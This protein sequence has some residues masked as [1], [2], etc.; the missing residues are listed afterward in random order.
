MK[1][2]HYSTEPFSQLKT[3]RYRKPPTKEEIDKATQIMNFR[4]EIGLYF[5]H[6]SFFFE[7]V[8]IKNMGY[9]FRN[10]KHDFWFKGNR[11]FEHVIDSSTINNFKFIIVETDEI[12]KFNNSNWPKNPTVEN[13]IKFFEER[14][15][16]R[17]KLNIIGSSNHELESFSSKYIGKLLYYYSKAYKTNEEEDMLKYAASVPHLMLY[18]E[19]GYINL[20]QPPIL[21]IIDNQKPSSNEL[22]NWKT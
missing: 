22:L 4:K 3:V 5:D 11:I 2:Y 19:S 18:P 6:I 13:K 15:K 9:F 8:P 16:L 14:S 21:K 12:T 1:L 10:V 7:P 20:I 17:E